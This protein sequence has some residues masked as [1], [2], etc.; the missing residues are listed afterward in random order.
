M[1]GDLHHM[2][3]FTLLAAFMLGQFAAVDAE[4]IH[5]IKLKDIV[6]KGSPFPGDIKW[7]FTKF[8]IAKDGTILKRFESATAPESR[9][10]IDAIDDAVK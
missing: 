7:N 4:S 10:L 5:D 2:K 8:L 9:E 3:T 6:G 1:L